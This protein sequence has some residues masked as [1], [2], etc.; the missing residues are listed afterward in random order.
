MPP[1]VLFLQ[2]PQEAGPPNGGTVAQPADT[3]LPD[4]DAHPLPSSSPPSQAG[5]PHASTG[6]DR[7]MQEAPQAGASERKGLS[8]EAAP[9][10]LES[11]AEGAR[12]GLSANCGSSSGGED[13][14]S[15]EEG[16][17]SQE[18]QAGG[19][20]VQG[21]EDVGPGGL[22]PPHQF[23][24]HLMAHDLRTLPAHLGS[25]PSPARQASSVRGQSARS[26]SSSPSSPSRAHLPRQP[27]LSPRSVPAAAA[28][29]AGAAATAAAATAAGA[30]GPPFSR[31]LEP[32]AAMGPAPHTVSHSTPAHL[33]TDPPPGAAA[34]TPA[35]AAGVNHRQAQV[36]PSGS[37]AATC[38]GRYERAWERWS[39]A[40]LRQHLG[41]STRPLSS[42]ATDRARPRSARPARAS[43]RPCSAASTS[44]GVVHWWGD[45]AAAAGGG[46]PGAPQAWE[47][48]AGAGTEAGAV[49]GRGC[50]Q[51]GA[52]AGVFSFGGTATGGAGC[53]G[54]SYSEDGSRSAAEP[55][56]AGHVHAPP[57]GATGEAGG[58]LKYEEWFARMMGSVN[59]AE[60]GAQSAEPAVVVRQG[61][62]V[63]GLLRQ[64][65]TESDMAASS[66]E[67]GGDA[68]APGSPPRPAV[69]MGH[70]SHEQQQQLQ[71]QQEGRVSAT[72]LARP[73]TAPS[74]R[75]GGRQSQAALP[76]VCARMCVFSS[77]CVCGCACRAL[78]RH[79]A[80]SAQDLSRTGWV[81]G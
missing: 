40:Q 44:G 46:S 45:G 11:H 59:E 79:I 81:E 26:M 37:V 1:T 47:G 49:T 73:S 43:A 31:F 30:V 62:D 20:G 8:G 18:G 64:S 72:R 14:G 25:P 2:A 75:F 60:G 41:L 33:C 69:A 3:K 19:A 54:Q 28:V 10:P 70:G 58:V 22:L 74:V 67:A 51:A 9:A 78:L 17:G 27:P 66:S 68:P 4:G 16:P 38:A 53:G 65:T 52:P 76:Q 13:G 12:H 7:T 61:G 23:A 39:P 6:Q 80:L 55:A 77:M 57:E 50:I 34:S 32:D 42:A 48:P 63:Q 5:T 15:S 36:P 35:R 21:D 24:L 56:Q 71:Q 29:A